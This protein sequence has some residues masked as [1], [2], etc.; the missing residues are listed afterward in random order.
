MALRFIPSQTVWL[1]QVVISCSSAGQSF[2]NSTSTN[3]TCPTAIPSQ[4]LSSHAYQAH[5]MVLWSLVVR[6]TLAYKSTSTLTHSLFLT[7]TTLLAALAATTLMLPPL[8]GCTLHQLALPVQLVAPAQM[9]RISLPRALLEDIHLTAPLRVRCAQQELTLSV[10]QP[11]API[12]L[13]AGTALAQ[14]PPAALPAW[15]VQQVIMGKVATWLLPV[16]GPALLELTLLAMQPRAPIVQRESTAQALAPP[17]ALPAWHVRLATSALKALQR[18][19]LLGTSAP[20]A[21]TV[22]P[23]PPKCHAPL[24]AFVL[25]ALLRL[26]PALLGSSAVAPLQWLL[27]ATLPLALI[28]TRFIT[29]IMLTNG[30][31]QPWLL[32][33]PIPSVKTMVLCSVLSLYL[34]APLL[35]TS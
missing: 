21:F 30:S 20:K 4:A 12:V 31:L 1:R 23:Q 5:G 7:G 13:R 28:H 10:M 15:P 35:A 25:K 24:A 2:L 16:L 27:L 11:L 29:I 32:P 22:P 34:P 19:Q 17:A 9:G 26:S 18:A 8:G 14:A 3:F 33:Q 6:L